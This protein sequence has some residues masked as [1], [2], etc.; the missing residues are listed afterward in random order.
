MTSVVSRQAEQVMDALPD[1]ESEAGVEELLVLG[2]D[3]L[4]HLFTRVT[5]GDGVQKAWCGPGAARST[6]ASP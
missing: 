1:V 3:A 4:S 6:P 2:Q 5:G